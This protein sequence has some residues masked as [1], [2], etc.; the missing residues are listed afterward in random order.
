MGRTGGIH[1]SPKGYAGR[2]GTDVFPL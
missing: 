1:A 2:G